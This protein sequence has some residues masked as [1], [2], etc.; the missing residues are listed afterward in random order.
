MKTIKYTETEALRIDVFLSDELEDLSRSEIQKLIK[1]QDILVNGNKTKASYKLEEGDLIEVAKIVEEEF[2]ITPIDYPLEVIYE[3]DDLIII[4]K[5]RGLVVYPGAGREDKS[6]VAALLG[7]NVSLFESEDKE[8]I[9]IVHRL[10]KD[11][12]GLMVLSKSEDA[13]FKLMELFKEREI[14]RKYYAL[15]DGEILHDYGTIDAPIGR[16]ENNRTKMSITSDGREAKTYFRVKERLNNATLV[17]CELYSGR[18]HQ[19]RVHMQYIKHSIIGDPLYR[20]KTIVKADHLMLQSYYL[21]FV[22]PVSNE[23]MNFELPLRE[24]FNEL[25]NEWSK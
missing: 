19:I 8:R 1:S 5:P 2:T 23:T 7:M 14:T 22:H 16:D 15:V 6:V 3:D 18:T 11:T 10:D 21:E 12:S 24:D 4:N 25:I 17:E 13:H 9:G 20:K